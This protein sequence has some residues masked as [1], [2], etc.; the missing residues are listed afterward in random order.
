MAREDA[1]CRRLSE[2]PEV[3]PI[4]ATGVLAAAGDL[5]LF[6]SG[7]SFAAWLGLAFTLGLV[8]KERARPLQ[9]G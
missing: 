6:D 7:R 3:G 8:S 5:H 4:V 9:S 1:N 2:I